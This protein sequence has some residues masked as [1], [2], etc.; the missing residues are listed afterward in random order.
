V[1]TL[2]KDMSEQASTSNPDEDALCDLMYSL[3]LQKQD[4]TKKAMLTA[5]HDQGSEWQAITQDRINRSWKK[6]VMRNPEKLSVKNKKPKSNMRVEIWTDGASKRNNGDIPRVA[7]IGVVFPIEFGI[8]PL[9]GPVS[10]N[11]T[12]NATTKAAAEIEAVIIGL[13]TASSHGYDKVEVNLDSNIIKD[14]MT[15]WTNQREIAVRRKTD[16]SQPKNLRMIQKLHDLAR[17]MDITWNW[18]E[19]GSH[20]NSVLA[21][22]LASAGCLT[23]EA[24]MGDS[25]DSDHT[26]DSEKELHARLKRN[27]DSGKVYEDA[28]PPT[29]LKTVEP[30]RINTL[31]SKKLKLCFEMDPS[32]HGSVIGK[33]VLVLSHHEHGY[34]LVNCGCAMTRISEDFT[35]K[36]EIAHN[37]NFLAEAKLSM[38]SQATPT[39]VLPAGAAV[40]V[41]CTKDYIQ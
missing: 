27:I 34:G 35:L 21:N 28:I 14:I 32:V 30:V 40:A 3:K 10:E 15:K 16:E 22:A 26:G 37:A 24:C 38:V 6:M 11:M 19:R 7:G 5:V 1:D 20:P 36:V 13:E 8:K 2:K 25:G 39:L 31:E 18:I 41:M 33:E 12:E 23:R 9:F 4:L 17:E 29:A